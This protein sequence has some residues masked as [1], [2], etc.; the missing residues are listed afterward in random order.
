MQRQSQLVIFKN[1]NSTLNLIK[2]SK[3]DDQIHED[4]LQLFF[5]IHFNTMDDLDL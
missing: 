5:P 3:K 4:H 2:S 1:H